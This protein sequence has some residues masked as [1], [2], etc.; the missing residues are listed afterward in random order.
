[1]LALAEGLG[2]ES[3]KAKRRGD[4]LSVEIR[5]TSDG[6]LIKDYFAGPRRYWQIRLADGTVAPIEALLAR[7]DPH[8]DRP[9]LAAR[10]DY[11]QGL[12]SAWATQSVAPLPTHAWVSTSWSQ[13]TFFY[14][15]SFMQW[16]SSRLPRHT[17]LSI[18]NFGTLKGASIVPVPLEQRLIGTAQTGLTSDAELI[19]ARASPYTV[20]DYLPYRVSIGPVLP[21]HG[22]RSGADTYTV[23]SGALAYN[24]TV[25]Q[26]AIGWARANF[27]PDRSGLGHL[28][29]VS[30]RR[31]T[32]LRVI[33]QIAAGESDNAAFGAPGVAAGHVALID[34]GGGDDTV[35][36]GPD[37]FAYGNDGDDRLFGGALVYGGAGSDTLVA[38]LF[39]D[40]GSGDDVLVGGEGETRFHVDPAASGADLVRDDAGLAREELTARYYNAIG[41]ALPSRVGPTLPDGGLGGVWTV[42]GESLAALEDGLYRLRDRASNYESRAIELRLNDG[43]SRA[44]YARLEDLRAELAAAGVPYRAADVRRLERLDDLRATDA[45][46][47]ARFA[48]LGLIEQ[49]TL[50]FGPGVALEDL[51]FRWRTETFAEPGGPV[52]RAVPELSWAPGKSVSIVIPRGSDPLDTGIERL[53]FADGT[54]LAIGALLALGPPA[55][56]PD[57][58]QGTSG[59]DLLQAGPEGAALLG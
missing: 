53:R 13:T 37:D 23:V 1:T 9:A 34:A 11:R 24:V 48:A 50:E 52:S 30:L 25:S 28:P 26:Y 47:L 18:S 56:P 17:S 49:D 2:L 19:V 33:E 59:S 10:E 42:A 27:L 39:M 21:G 7:P 51:S 12:L 20:T 40:G 43:P 15:H 38:G 22:G 41:V 8:A 57:I 32:E 46:G 4:H 3:L 54:T 5:G 16:Q 44:Y 45:A 55:P 35:H 14:Q 58:V 31:V 36:A 29:L 6:V